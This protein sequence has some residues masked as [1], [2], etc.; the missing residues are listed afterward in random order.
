MNN[1]IITYLPTI[2]SYRERLFQIK[3]LSTHN[4]KLH[5]TV[6][7]KE[8]ILNE[9]LNS[10]NFKVV[11]LNNNIFLKSIIL[12]FYFLINFFF[13]K[14]KIIMIDWFKN[15]PITAIFFSIR[16]NK[17]Y[18]FYPVISDYY[19]LKKKSSL[20]SQINDF[21]Y[22]YL[23]SKHVIK[24][25]TC[26]FFAEKVVVQ[27][28][29]LKEIYANVYKINPRKLSVNYNF[30]NSS[31][32]KNQFITG[33]NLTIGYIG[34]I[35]KHKGSKQLIEICKNLNDCTFYIAGN[36]NGI[37]NKKDFKNLNQIDNVNLTGFLNYK[38]KLDFYNKIDILILLSFHEGSPRV[39]GEFFKYNKPI[40]SYYNLGLDYSLNNDHIHLFD[41][42]TDLIEI[43]STIN[44][45]RNKKINIFHQPCFKLN[46]KSLNVPK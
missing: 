36:A 19:W 3:N 45:Y 4:K 21:R 10:V 16:K 15:F 14:E 33:K 20:K 17:N 28:K 39:I 7:T 1:K 9:K 44:N 34:N 37:K 23:R 24:E 25:F 26:L 12:D 18:Y 32:I 22:N 13:G 6:F 11:T 43:V 27:S 2:S 35:E 42:T 29:K 8:K 31:K 38:E 41:Y 30:F 46:N 5:I 40:I